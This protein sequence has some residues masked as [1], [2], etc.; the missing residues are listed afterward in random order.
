MRECGLR[1]FLFVAICLGTPSVRSWGMAQKPEMRNTASP[2]AAVPRF[3]HVLVIVIEN[4]EFPQVV[5]NPAMPNFNLWARQYALLT[6]YYGVTH[7]SLPNYLALIGGDFFGIQDDCTDCSIDALSLPDL[8]EA[9]GRS[10]KAYL[11]GLPSAGFIGGS[12]GRYR[13]KHNPFVYFD[14]VRK[15]PARLERSIVPLEM[16]TADLENGQMPDFAFIMPDMCNSS[17]DCAVDVTD[18][19]LGRI[20]GSILGSPAFDAES[21]LVLTFDEGTTTQGCCGAPATAGG[22]RIATILISPLVLREYQDATP[23]SH[24]SLLKTILAAWGL[25]A[26]GH[27][28][29]PAVN[30]ILKPWR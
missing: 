10:W 30:M 20:V 11:E 3:S 1:T 17:H 29:D 16:L 14:P 5:G 6:R 27:T 24:Y 7:P 26:I 15:D 22:G 4:K 13:K 2:A 8:L 23:Y 25:G 18:G 9:G 28:S 12:S 21:L 19:W